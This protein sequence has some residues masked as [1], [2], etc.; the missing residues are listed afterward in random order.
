MLNEKK[1]TKL[2]VEHFLEQSFFKHKY[3]DINLNRRLI[4]EHQR[5]V[6]T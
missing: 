3:R 5:L 4:K 2:L 6:S 1:A